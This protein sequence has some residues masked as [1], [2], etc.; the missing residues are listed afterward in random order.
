M[1]NKNKKVEKR[2]LCEWTFKALQTSLIAKNIKLG[3]RKIGMWR[4][5]GVVVIGV[6][7]PSTGFKEED[8]GSGEEGNNL[9]GMPVVPRK[10]TGYLLSHKGT[11]FHGTW[12]RSDARQVVCRHASTLAIGA[13]KVQ[14]GTTISCAGTSRK[15]ACEAL[16]NNPP[17]GH[18]KATHQSL[19]CQ[20]GGPSSNWDGVPTSSVEGGPASRAKDGPT[21]SSEE[22]NAACSPPL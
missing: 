12:S 19:H 21:S 18:H 9:I 20:G 15:G 7:A 5:D 3:F 17:H 16:P 1:L 4:L 10:G 14:Q 2:D 13:C 6:M 8:D 11:N 22:V